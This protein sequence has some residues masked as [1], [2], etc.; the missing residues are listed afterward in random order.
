MSAGAS[1]VHRHEQTFNINAWSRLCTGFDSENSC[2]TVPLLF[3]VDSGG[4]VCP[5]IG[6]VYGYNGRGLTFREQTN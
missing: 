5:L 2:I 4:K 3:S 1:F 6:D